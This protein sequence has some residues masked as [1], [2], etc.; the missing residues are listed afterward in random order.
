[1]GE[2]KIF[3]RETNWV[4]GGEI[5]EETNWV[6]KEKLW[7]K[8]K[9]RRQWSWAKSFIWEK[10]FK[11]EKGEAGEAER[12]GKCKGETNRVVGKKRRSK[13]K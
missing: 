3:L 4:D 2:H 1:M 11:D 9:N 12:M 10:I 13:N 8:N 5:K 7:K 6:R